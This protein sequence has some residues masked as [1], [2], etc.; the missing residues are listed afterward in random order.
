ME[1]VKLGI[2]IFLKNIE[3]ALENPVFT[4]AGRKEIKLKYEIASLQ[5]ATIHK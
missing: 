4:F 3:Q 1:E 2:R 5:N